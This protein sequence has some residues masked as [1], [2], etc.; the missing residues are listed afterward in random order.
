MELTCLEEDNKH[1][2]DNLESKPHTSPD[3]FTT[4]AKYKFSHLLSFKYYPSNPPLKLLKITILSPFINNLWNHFYS[5][6]GLRSPFHF[7]SSDY[8]PT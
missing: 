3:S 1:M 4:M 2:P 7:F 6:S 8:F 5:E